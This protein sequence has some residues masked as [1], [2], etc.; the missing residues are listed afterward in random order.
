MQPT[1]RNLASSFKKHYLMDIQKD[2]LRRS[3]C[4]TLP[5]RIGYCIRPFLVGISFSR[6]NH[7]NQFTGYIFRGWQFTVIHIVP[8]SNGPVDVAKKQLIN[9]IYQFV[10]IICR[11][12]HGLLRK[13]WRDTVDT[14]IHVQRPV[15]F[16]TVEL[17]LVFNY[18]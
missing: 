15:S 10:T 3:K 17:S 8:I 18:C 1:V 6:M 4:S 16:L 9:T 7:R 5:H 14:P 2:I 12:I 13:Q 11:T